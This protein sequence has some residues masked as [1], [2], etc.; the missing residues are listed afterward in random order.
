MFFLSLIIEKF[1]IPATH[2]HAR[3]FIDNQLKEEI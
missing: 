3:A 1:L 2:M